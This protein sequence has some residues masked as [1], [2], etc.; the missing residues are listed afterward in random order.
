LHANHGRAL[1]CRH[2]TLRP[3]M[4]GRYEDAKQDQKWCQQGG[5]VQLS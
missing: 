2:S 1:T 5:T 3:G 4:L